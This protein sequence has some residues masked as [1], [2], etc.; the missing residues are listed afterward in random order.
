LNR[1]VQQNHRDVEWSRTIQEKMMSMLMSV[2][3]GP[4]PARVATT[5]AA[6]ARHPVEAA[7][8]EL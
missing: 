8:T 7:G 6:E 2:L 4:T 5:P 1:L 3:S